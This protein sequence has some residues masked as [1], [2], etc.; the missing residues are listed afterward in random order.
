MISPHYYRNCR[1]KPLFNPIRSRFFTVLIHFGTHTPR[2]T[3]Q[4][5]DNAKDAER[6][7]Q[8][9]APMHQADIYNYWLSW[10]FQPCNCKNTY[11][12]G[13]YLDIFFWLWCDVGIFLPKVFWPTLRKNCSSDWEKCLKFEAEG[14][15]FES[16]LR[17]LEQFIQT[18]K[19]QNNCW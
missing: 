7:F 18:M 10:N 17:L 14:W 6:R 5:M 2:P 15:E 16:F 8:R 9:L 1:C 11:L 19:S 4:L 3:I 13:K 12:V